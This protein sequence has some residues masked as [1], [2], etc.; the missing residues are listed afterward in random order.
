MVQRAGPR[1]DQLVTDAGERI[2]ISAAPITSVDV[3][4]A[5]AIADLDKSLDDAGIELCF[6]E[7]KDPV[8]DKIRRF[9]LFDEFRLFPTLNLR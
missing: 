5:D 6:A 7:L 4:S 2:V 9:G 1:R 3:T 8:K